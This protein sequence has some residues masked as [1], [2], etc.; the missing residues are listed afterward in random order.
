M[1][2]SPLRLYASR[3]AR[4]WRKPGS[5]DEVPQF[6]EHPAATLRFKAREALKPGSGDEVPQF[7][8]Q[9]KVTSLSIFDDEKEEITQAMI[10]T[11]DNLP[12]GVGEWQAEGDAH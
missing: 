5:G 6:K 9:Q 11:A 2:M 7:K 1:A 10:A 8:E 3:H 12:I 4:R